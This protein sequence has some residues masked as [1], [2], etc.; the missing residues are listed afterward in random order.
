MRGLLLTLCLIGLIGFIGYRT[1]IGGQTVSWHQRLTVIVETPNGQVRGAS[2]TEV[3]NTEQRGLLVPPD[4]GN[5]V[6]RYRGEAVVVE[7][8]PGRYLLALL[9][10]VRPEGDAPFWIYSAYNLEG[11][12]DLAEKTYSKKMAKVKGQSLDSPV[13]LPPIAYPMLITFD[14]I[15]KPETVHAVNPADMAATFGP[16]VTLRGVTLE[17]TKEGVTEGQVEGVLGTLKFIDKRG[18]ITISFSPNFQTELLEPDDKYLSVL[19]L[20]TEVFK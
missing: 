20:S 3:T 12:S 17:I 4:A 14:D 11:P 8:L 13:P 1:L 6:P 16:G 5:I 10:G 7:V 2:V 19:T 18:P 15:A 9:K